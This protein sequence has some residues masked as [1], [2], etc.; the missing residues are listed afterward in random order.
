MYNCKGWN[1]S[2]LGADRN[3]CEFYLIFLSKEIGI[4]L[5]QLYTKLVYTKCCI[6][7]AGLNRSYSGNQSE[8]E[9]IPEEPK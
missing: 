2:Y 7:I 5:C 8:N 9:E 3:P 4:K 1:L 6:K